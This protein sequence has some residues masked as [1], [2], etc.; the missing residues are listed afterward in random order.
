[1]SAPHSN[2]EPLPASSLSADASDLE[3]RLGLYQVFLRLYEHHREL[4]DEILELEDTDRYRVRG[5]WQFVQAGLQ[6]GL[7]YLNTNLMDGKT[8]TLFQPQHCW[9]IGRDRNVGLSI[10]DKRLSRR[11]AM[12]QYVA[13]QGFYLLDLESTNGTYLNGEPIRRP[14]LL[15]DGDRVRL[16]TLSFVFF[17][18]SASRTLAPVPLDL[19]SQL[20]DSQAHSA[21]T[22]ELG[23]MEAADIQ[24]AIAAME[25]LYPSGEKETFVF[26]A[27]PMH[28]DSLGAESIGQELSI[29]EKADILDRFLKRQ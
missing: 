18:N 24:P 13:E 21:S 22:I 15:R 23:D 7:A 17:Y 19:T 9:V 2:F 25:D 10:R 1:M 8:Q 12:I 16:G 14:T 29:S 28:A 3:Q 20:L 11:H 5:V 27:N 4:L 26:A 6:D